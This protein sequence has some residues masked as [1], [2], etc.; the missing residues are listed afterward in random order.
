VIVGLS[1]KYIVIYT[2]KIFFD[3]IV[4]RKKKDNVHGRGTC[5]GVQRVEPYPD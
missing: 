1:V 3:E 5:M 4:M 2:L